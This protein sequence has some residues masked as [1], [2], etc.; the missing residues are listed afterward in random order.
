MLSPDNDRSHAVIGPLLKGAEARHLTDEEL[1][2]FVA[3][4]PR[5]AARAEA[6]RE[7]RTCEI[8]VVSRIVREV[9][10]IYPYEAHHQ[11]AMAK[12]VR[13]VRYVST[14]ATH[15]MLLNDPVW[16]DDKFLLWLKTILQSFEF[17]DRA[18]KRTLVFGGTDD[19]ALRAMKPKQRS[20][21]AT[22]TKLRD[23]YQAA[24]TAPSA[25]L[26]RPFL[27]QALDVLSSD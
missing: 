23:G 27:Q 11:L 10:A 12:C 19:P 20:I 14:Y 8:E 24:L 1:A 15:A 17:P 21:H 26:M 22:Y 13:D 5:F 18:T 9:F 25:A 6:A 4:G 16:F 2:T 7:V 3:Q